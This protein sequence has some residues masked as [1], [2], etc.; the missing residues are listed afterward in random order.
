MANPLVTMVNPLAL[1]FGGTV[2]LH[3][4]ARYP[5]QGVAARDFGFDQSWLSR[6]ETG[7]HVPD[8]TTAERLEKALHCLPGTLMLAYDVLV[9]EALPT[10]VRAW[11]PYEQAATTLRAFQLSVVPGLLQTADYARALLGDEAAVRARLDRQ[12]ILNRDD[13]PSLHCLIDESILLRQIGEARV[14]HDQIEEIV[15]RV[16]SSVSIQV[17]PLTATRPHVGEFILATIPDQKSEVAYVG[18][19]TH[20]L[21][22]TS[23][24]EIA[25]L[26]EAWKSILKTAYP[27][28]ET[29]D[30]LR[31]VKVDKWT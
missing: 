23:E 11:L 14:T 27:L 22:I 10:S 18:A 19:G 25:S 4:Q 21:V 5:S 29:L 20:G 12:A 6:V 30:L 7:Q 3:R 31:K 26:K 17:V 28:V 16:S 2:R 9:A 24:P 1:V 8:R 15:A 13:A